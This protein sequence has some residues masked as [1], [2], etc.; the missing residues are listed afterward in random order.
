M[1][2]RISII[3]AKVRGSVRINVLLTKPGGGGKAKPEGLA[4]EPRVLKCAMRMARF[5]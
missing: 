1:I 2:A 5:G 3:L 4:G